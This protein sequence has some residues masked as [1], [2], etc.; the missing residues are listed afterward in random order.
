VNS[1]AFAPVS[2]VVHK[3]FDNK[4]NVNFGATLDP[5]D[6]S[7]NR[8]NTFNLN[9][10]GSLFRMTSANVTLNYSISS[11]A[12]DKSKDTNSQTTR[13]GGREDDLFGTNVM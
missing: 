4:M 13:N 9:N 5:Y 3:F 10:G 12:K 8:I 1:L 11:S 6:N 2:S 7:G